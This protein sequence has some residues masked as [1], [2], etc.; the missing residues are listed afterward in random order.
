MVQEADVPL[1]LL[2]DSG[3]FTAWKAGKS[4]KLD[5]Y[6]KQISDLPFK[7][8][9][10]FTLDVVGNPKAT[11][12]NFAS[13]IK[14][15]FRP[16]P[17][18]TRGEGLGE[19]EYYYQHSDI[20][21]LGGLVGTAGAEG[22]VRAVMGKIGSRKVHWLGFT[23]LDFLSYY[24]PFSIDSSS[25]SSGYRYGF[26]QL[27]VGKGRWR[28]L[29]REHFMQR[30]DTETMN[31]FKL[32][33]E[34]PRAFAFKSEWKNAGQINAFR[35]LPF[36][37]YV[38]YMQDIKINFG[39]KMFIVFG[40]GASEDGRLAIDCFKWWKNSAFFPKKIYK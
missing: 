30:P 31:L 21:G 38:R 20:L 25:I 22:F 18:F 13:L 1:D 10:Y 2:V 14:S 8:W 26:I 34:D 24:R 27:Y 4:V 5:D 29:T 12:Q 9:N 16:I 40:A 17:V 11:K 19:I 36:K 37:C 6:K 33:E 35:R 3:A 23:N 39:T 15:G 7:P 32:Y 28:Q